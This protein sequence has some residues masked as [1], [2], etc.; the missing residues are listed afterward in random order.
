M[1][2]EPLRLYTKDGTPE[3]GT[4]DIV[5][6]L[7]GVI[8]ATQ[9]SGREPY[10][11]HASKRRSPPSARWRSRPSR[12]AGARRGTPRA[13][14]AHIYIR[15]GQ[16]AKSRSQMPTPRP[17]TR[18]ISRTPRE[19]FLRDDDYGHNLHF[20][21]AARVCRQPRAS[22]SAAQ[23]TVKLADPIAAQMVMIEPFARK[24]CRCWCDLGRPAILETKAP[25]VTRVMQAR[26]ITSRMARAGRHW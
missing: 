19:W 13:H 18:S 12:I 9:P 26:C 21:S 23:R 20:E 8:S 2:L 15:T 22:R 25:P 6:A 24:S 11:I 10:Y 17:W 16:Y 4:A 7:E 1:K 14:A 5:N 3:P